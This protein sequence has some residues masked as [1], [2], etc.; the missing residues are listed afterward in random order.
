ME[1]RKVQVGEHLLHVR[2]WN[3]ASRGP[4]IVLLHGL[5]VSSRYLVPLGNRL[6]SDCAVYAVDLP[7]FG[8]SSKP[9]RTLDTAEL[10]QVFAQWMR[11][12][13]IS[14]A[15]VVANSYGCEVAIEALNIVDEQARSVMLMGP[16][17]DPRARSPF[18]QGLRLLRSLIHEP[19]WFVPC[20]I[21]DLID[22]GIRPAVIFIRNMVRYD[23][24]ANAM[25][26]RIP[27]TVLRGEYDFV[28]P[29]R[30]A[31]ELCNATHAQLVLIAN[32]GHIA[33]GCKPD[34]VAEAVRVA[35]RTKRASV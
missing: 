13:G 15:T 12:D 11:V 25:A 20:A 1:S 10:G 14:E 27:I 18:L 33:H 16:T 8:K 7:G 5:I 30:W 6:A 19:W 9:R 35:S 24:V 34:A 32:A 29:D 17:V 3:A 28:A 21:H 2:T 22:C 31:Q 4:V 26:L 23:T